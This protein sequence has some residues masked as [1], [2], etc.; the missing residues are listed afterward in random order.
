[1]N[2][3]IALA[4]NSKVAPPSAIGQVYS[5]AGTVDF[6]SSSPENNLKTAK[7]STLVSTLSIL[8][9]F[10]LAGVLVLS[11]LAYLTVVVG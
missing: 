6:A 9:G 1:M 5:S 8:G 7:M 10:L 4:P 3:T 2:R 11:F